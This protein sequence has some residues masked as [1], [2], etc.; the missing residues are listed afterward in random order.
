MYRMPESADF[1]CNYYFVTGETKTGNMPYG[2]KYKVDTCQYY[3]CGVRV[4]AARESPLATPNN[5]V[6]LTG[7]R[8]LRKNDDKVYEMYESGMNDIDIG[9]AFGVSAST[10]ARW[11][12]RKGLRAKK[13]KSINWDGVEKTIRQ[14]YSLK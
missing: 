9:K 11:R 2:E 13:Q 6:V 3:Q 4:R 14:G 1:G 12:K 10:I 5:L 7:L 8:T